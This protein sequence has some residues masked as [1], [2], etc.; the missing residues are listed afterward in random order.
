MRNSTL[1]KLSG[2]KSFRR[3]SS[4]ML[5]GRG[6][7]L[8]NIEKSMRAVYI[9]DGFSEELKG[10]CEYFLETGDL[11][12]FTEEELVNLRCFVN[13]DQAGAEALIV[14][15]ECEPLDYRKLFIHGVKPHVYVALKLFVD[16]WKEKIKEYHVDVSTD[17]IDILA[18]TPID[19]LKENTAWKPIDTLIKS[20]DNWT[21]SQRYYYLAK[22]TCHSA[23]YGIEAGMFQM[24][25]LEKS[26]GKIVI[27][28][29]EAARFLET[30]RG[31][32][33]EIPERN[34]RIRRQVDSTKVLYNLF[35]FPYQITNYNITEATYKEYYAWSAQ[36][37]VGEITRI[38]ISDLQE[39]IE[40]EKLKWDFL[41]DN[42]DSYLVQCPLTDVQKCSSKMETFMNQELT[43][44]VDGVKFRMKTE[45]QVGFNFAPM[46]S[47]NKL[48]LGK[49]EWI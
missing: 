48:G 46:K 8:Q 18:T 22:Q 41:Q 1:Y 17:D 27:P 11:T 2:A 29:E 20:S 9:P 42:H 4:K 12:V 10:R 16:T 36:S 30:Y 3:S 37:T 49:I 7:N 26:G 34:N 38:A 21:L 15:Y 40:R 19:R 39:Y 31:L 13:R 5:G 44:P 43:S 47:D 45:C 6:S 33:P 25:L 14:A 32:F 23:N 28:R 24:N 35:G